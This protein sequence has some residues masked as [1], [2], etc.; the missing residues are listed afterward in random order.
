MVRTLHN[1]HRSAQTHSRRCTG[2]EE[3]MHSQLPSP[4]CSLV[5]GCCGSASSAR[6]LRPVAL[7]AVGDVRSVSDLISS[8]RRG[9][10]LTHHLCGTP[11]LNLLSLLIDVR[12][13]TSITRTL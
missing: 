5:A 9:W 11:A 13:G 8:A 6:G 10:S 12:T 1:Q 4:L 7:T 2:C 3:S